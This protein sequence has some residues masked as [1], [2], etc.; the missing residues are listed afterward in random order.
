MQLNLLLHSWV[1]IFQAEVTEDE[2]KNLVVL[3]SDKM[4]WQWQT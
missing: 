1:V 3:I 4:W 2:D